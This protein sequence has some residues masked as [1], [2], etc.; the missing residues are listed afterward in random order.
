MTKH[1]NNL[2]FETICSSEVEELRHNP[3]HILPIYASSSFVFEDTQHSI[4]VFTNQKDG[5][6]YSRYANPTVDSVATKLARLETFDT[7][8]EGYCLLTNSGM[9]A[10]SLVFAAFLKSGDTILTQA[11]LYGGTTELINKVFARFGINAIYVDLTNLD[12]VEKALNEHNITMIYAETPAN[13]SLRCIDLAATANLA[14]QYDCMT[15]VDNT[16]CTPYIQRPIGLGIDV[17]IHSTTKALNGHGNSIGGAVIAD[18]KYKNQLWQS[19]KL[20]GLNPSPFEAW[21]LHNG[22]KTLTLRVSKACDN[23]M[24]IAKYLETHP[25]VGQVNYPGLSNHSSHQVA[26]SQMSKFGSMLSFELKGGF[27]AGKG[28]MDNV[29]LITLAPTLGDLD[30]LMLH[31]ASS[32][33]LNIQKEIRESVGITDGLVRMSVGIEEPEDLIKDLS[34]ALDTIS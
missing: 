16:F 19:Y 3:S 2:S 22:M 13:P 12:V 30:T 33:H 18:I 28:L 26:S 23:A 31:P 11:D 14:K 4:D 7:E 15:V 10:I 20:I 32:S 8:V 29:N 1:S 6:L 34:A 27:D 25:K 9:S 5:H 17:V 24:V 21:L